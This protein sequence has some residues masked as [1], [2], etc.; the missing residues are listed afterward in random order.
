MSQYNIQSIIGLAGVSE[1]EC[2][3]AQQVGHHFEV[4]MLLVAIWIVVE[5][6]AELEGVFPR[7]YAYFTDLAIWLFFITE[8]VILTYLVNDKLRYLRSNWINLVIIF[9]GVPVIW[10]MSSYAGILRSLRLLLLAAILINL[11]DTIRQVLS[12]NHLG[13]TLAIALMI[14]ML[15][16]ILIAGIDPNIDSVWEGLWWAWVTVTTVGYGDVVPVS[17]PG[18]LFGAILILFG[19]GIFSLLTANFSA[20]FI[21]KEEQEAKEIEKETLQK[22]DMIEQRI[23][24][25]E[26]SINKFINK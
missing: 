4:P 9:M 10:G 5:W 17:V 13:I 8:T 11:S 20:F 19:L 7:S 2:E 1:D 25:L 24:D 16:G 26:R 12:R 21:S 6:Y 3:K 23:N 15:S 18:K 14:I 22:L